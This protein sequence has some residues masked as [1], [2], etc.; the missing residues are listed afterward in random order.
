MNAIVN[1]TATAN[2]VCAVSIPQPPSM[3]SRGFVL[4]LVLLLFSAVAHAQLYGITVNAG[5]L[6]ELPT[7][8]E[9]GGGEYIDEPAP[10]GPLTQTSYGIIPFGH[11]DSVTGFDTIVNGIVTAS[12][13]AEINLASA[14]KGSLAFGITSSGSSMPDAPAAAYNYAG[15]QWTDTLYV[16]SPSLKIGTP[17]KIKVTYLVDGRYHIPANGINGSD[18]EYAFQITDT[19]CGCTSYVA[20]EVT[21]NTS[22]LISSQ[23]SYILHAFSGDTLSLLNY[24]GSTTNG[25]TGWTASASVNTAIVYIDVFTARAFVTS[26]SGVDYSSSN[27]IVV[28][29]VVGNSES[30]AVNAL[31]SAGLGVGA[32]ST[33][34]SSK[35]PAGDVI[36]QWPSANSSVVS[37]APMN[38]VVSL[39]PKK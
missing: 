19:S 22:K 23:H 7:T 25:D 35:V 32:I 34:N 21:V 6:T 20:E 13:S 26:A 28:P 30:V 39:G 31:A 9:G 8:T 37:G 27:L 4:P 14:Y 5:L 1:R 16:Y 2:R 18:L 17:V 10:I 12:V 33:K 3:A 38:L 29:N 15:V 24:V 36:Q 11:S